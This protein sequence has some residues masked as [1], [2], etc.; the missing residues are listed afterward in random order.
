LELLGTQLVKT[1]VT[2]ELD[3]LVLASPTQV[4]NF[5]SPAAFWNNAIATAAGGGGGHS[6]NMSATL[7]W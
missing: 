1:L 4:V 2:K 7:Y 6:H 5:G 3:G